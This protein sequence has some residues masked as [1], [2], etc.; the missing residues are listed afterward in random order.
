MVFFGMAQQHY[1]RV[2]M[3]AVM[4]DGFESVLTHRDG[5]GESMLD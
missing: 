4:F 3:Q 5:G 1:A 2:G